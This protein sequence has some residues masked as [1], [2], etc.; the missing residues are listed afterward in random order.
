MRIVQNLWQH[1][2]AKFWLGAA[3]VALL[4]LNVGANFDLAPQQWEYQTRWFQIR[5]GD[6]LDDLQRLFTEVINRE[7]EQGWEFTGRCAHFNSTAGN[8]DY[9]VFRRRR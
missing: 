9:V 4:V 5:P 1:R 7:A 6:N 3:I 2:F 8:V